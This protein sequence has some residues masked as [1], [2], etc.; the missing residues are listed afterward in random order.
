VLQTMRASAKY[1]FW[2][3]LITFVGGFLLAE[4]SG[5]LGRASVTPGTPVAVVNGRDIP[6]LAWQQRVQNQVQQLQRSGRSLS[7][8]EVRLVENQAFDEMVNEVLLEQEYARRG[9]AVTDDELRLYAKQAP[10]PWLRQ[11]PDLLTDGQ[12]DPTKYERLLASPQARESGLLLALE[13]YYR[14]EIPKAKLF[15]QVTTGVY[16]TDAELWRSWKDLNDTAVV[17]FVAF[18]PAA[19]LKPDAS[20]SDSELRTYFD[21]HKEELRRHGRAVLSVVQI[22]RDVTAADSAAVRAKAERLRQEILGGAKFEEVARRESSDSVSAANGGDLGR[23]AK[24]RFVPAFETAAYA[25]QPGQISGP[26]LTQF[27]YHLIKVDDRKGDTL[28]L[29]HIL[30]PVQPSDSN[31]AAI[32][33]RADE[34]SRMAA[35]A[36]QPAKL[37]SAARKLG[38]KVE[39]VVAEE[40]QPAV[41]GGQVIPS[42]SAWAF[43][44]AK[45][46]ETSELYDSDAGYVV[47]RL[48]SLKEGAEDDFDALKEDVRARVTVMRAVEALVPQAQQL[49][50]AAAGSTLE[51]AA[52]AQKL[53][54]EKTP[55]FTR[56]SGAE[57]LGRL[58]EAVGVAFGLP[59]GTVSAPVKTDDAVYVLRVDRRTEADRKAW[60]GTKQIARMQRANQVREQQLQLFLQELR[61]SAKVSDRRKQLNAMMRRA[62]T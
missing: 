40:G 56:A 24:G 21:R 38:L 9:I 35:S 16:V 50:R 52:A 7:Q 45:V 33:R 59:I 29:R 19:N 60:E 30:L 42:V 48:D 22:R 61:R 5:L 4:T 17:S 39:R 1:I 53:A 36:D 23:G 54:V 26:V 20:I 6:Y 43:G 2:F 13:Q 25:L 3:I 8:D 11:N 44:G 10:P 12:F 55:P 41:L 32:D 49:A 37:D 15:D 57:G 14:Q 51:Q 47:A 31:S 58:N 27:G 62:E 18:R 46:G 34:L 28:A